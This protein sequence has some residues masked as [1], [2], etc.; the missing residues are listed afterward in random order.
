MA[1]FIIHL[2]SSIT[3]ITLQSNKSDYMPLS[4]VVLYILAGPFGLIAELLAEII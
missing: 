3:A 1:Y 2:L 4:L